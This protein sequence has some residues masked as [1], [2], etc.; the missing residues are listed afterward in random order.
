MKENGCASPVFNMSHFISS[1][2]EQH[3]KDSLDAAVTVTE[4]GTGESSH[5]L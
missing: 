5:I 3:L 1:E 2:F 4:E